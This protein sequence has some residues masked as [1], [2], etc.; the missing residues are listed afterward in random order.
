M[1]RVTGGIVDP[2]TSE[3]YLRSG[4]NLTLTCVQRVTQVD[5]ERER[6]LRRQPEVRWSKAEATHGTAPSQVPDDQLRYQTVDSSNPNA[7]YTVNQRPADEGGDLLHSTLV[8]DGVA[9]ADSGFYRCR[10][11]LGGE[12]SRILV[13]VVDSTCLY[14]SLAIY[15]MQGIAFTRGHDN[16]NT[17]K[18]KE[19]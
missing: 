5:I 9:R 8:K 15:L 13:I 6:A 10:L 14:C 2:R 11:G 4:D 18:Y 19:T 3:L 7:P 12:S 16:K 1:W 17:I